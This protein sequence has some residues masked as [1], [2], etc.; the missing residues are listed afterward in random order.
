VEEVLRFILLALSL[1]VAGCG[2]ALADSTVAGDWRADLGQGVRIDMNVTP[3]GDWSSETRQD[4]QLV[5]RMHGTY[6]QSQSEHQSG[7]LVFT[8]VETSAGTGSAQ[9]ETDQYQM[10]DNG[11]E[12]R[13]TSG[14]D[15]M[16]FKKQ[17]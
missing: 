13:L 6:K 7:T 1:L 17:R 11:Q 9:V 12:L 15:T 8:P 2:V 3:N 14:G 16:V 4:N 10:A 5:R